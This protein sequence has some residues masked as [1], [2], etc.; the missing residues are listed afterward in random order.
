MIGGGRGHAPEAARPCWWVTSGAV[1][2]G[3]QLWGPPVGSVCRE[4]PGPARLPSP[5]TSPMAAWSRQAVLTLY[6]ALLRQ[7]RGL[8]YTDRDFYLA[9]IR[10]EFR[11]NQG[12]Q[13]PEDKER[14]LEKGQA[15]LQSK[16]G[17]L[18]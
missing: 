15:F 9:F 16:L 10:R 1:P 14:Q 6:R 2:G 12:L 7:G 4:G 3:R 8:R 13:R 17:G 5:P 11:K 18:V